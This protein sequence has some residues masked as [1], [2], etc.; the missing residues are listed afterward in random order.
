MTYLALDTARRAK[1]GE[2]VRTRICSTYVLRTPD[3]QAGDAPPLTWTALVAGHMA[4]PA[5]EACMVDL[6]TLACL[7]LLASLIV[8][9]VAARAVCA[10]VCVRG[11][12]SRLVRIGVSRIVQVGRHCRIAK[13]ESGTLGATKGGHCQRKKVKVYHKMRRVSKLGLIPPN[14]YVPRT[15]YL[16]LSAKK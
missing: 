11:G 13:D 8:V 7:L 15:A 9:L 12:G 6:S 5:I 1:G 14:A 4:A 2:Q 3:G 16:S 10:I